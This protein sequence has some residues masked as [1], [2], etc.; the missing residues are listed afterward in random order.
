MFMPSNSTEKYYVT[1]TN[2][3]ASPS[4]ESVPS[5]VT[6]TVQ[7]CEVEIPSAFTPDDDK[8]NDIWE[9]KFLDVNFPEN[10]VKIYNRWG[11]LVFESQSGKYELYPWDGKI[12]GIDLPVSSYFYV[13][14]HNDGKHDPK[15]G[16]VTIIRK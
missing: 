16:T 8:T 4:C 9:L 15:K 14:E 2:T 10:I 6:I 7:S 12:D 1:E 11:N 3:T 13:I 5:S